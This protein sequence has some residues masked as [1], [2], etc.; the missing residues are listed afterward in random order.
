MKFDRSFYL[1]E[2]I[3]FFNSKRR[4]FN[5]QTF[6]LTGNGLHCATTIKMRNKSTWFISR[7]LLQNTLY[8]ESDNGLTLMVMKNRQQ[9][10]ID[11]PLIRV[12][13]MLPKG[14][15]C[16]VHRN[17]LV[18]KDAISEF[19]YYRTQLLAIVHGYRIPV[20]RRRGRMLLDNL[21]LL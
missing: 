3:W 17:Y 9:E 20:S 13:D 7:Y 16:R 8:F 12:E 5:I 11:I 15:F 21:D 19:R 18:N 4:K 14:M 1:A 10:I 2:N 6:N